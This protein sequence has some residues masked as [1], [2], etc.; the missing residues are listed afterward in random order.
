MHFSQ[1]YIL[2]L[3]LQSCGTVILFLFDWKLEIGN[4]GSDFFFILSLLVF[5][6]GGICYVYF[7]SSI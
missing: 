5:F 1:K 7:I 3:M 2:F 6:Y 4:N